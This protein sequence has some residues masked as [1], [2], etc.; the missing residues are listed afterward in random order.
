MKMTMES[1]DNFF[2]KAKSR[3]HLLPNAMEEAKGSAPH[4]IH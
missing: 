2:F 3:P 4:A 1:A